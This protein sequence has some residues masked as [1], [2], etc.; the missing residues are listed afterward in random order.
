M[1]LCRERSHGSKTPFAGGL[2]TQ[3]SPFGR[4]VIIRGGFAEIIFCISCPMCG[5]L[6]YLVCMA[7]LQ[8]S[9]YNM[10]FAERSVRFRK[11]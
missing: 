3:R 1:G 4:P 10:T 6:A 8:L 5:M 9:P 7:R 11:K 2:T